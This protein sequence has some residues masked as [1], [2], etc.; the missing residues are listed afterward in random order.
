[1]AGLDQTLNAAAD[2]PGDVRLAHHVGAP[3]GADHLGVPEQQ[4]VDPDL[5]DRAAGEPDDDHATFLAQ[6]ADAV[7]EAIAADR[8]EHH[9]D[10]AAGDLLR[11]VLPAAVGADDV[12]GAGIPGHRLLLIAGNDRDRMGAK[13]RR[14]LQRRSADAAGRAVDEH[15]FAVL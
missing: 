6:G 14:H 3:T 10:T 13:T 8:I 9:V 11:L 5:G 7:G 1:M 2:L 12:L 15:P 4:P